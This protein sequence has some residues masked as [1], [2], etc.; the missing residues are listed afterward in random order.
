M[1]HI[2][3]ILLFLTFLSASCN[4]QKVEN[5]TSATEIEIPCMKLG[6]S[7]DTHFR[8]YGSAMSS[9]IKLAKEKAINSAKANLAKKIAESTTKSQLEIENLIETTYSI[10]CEKYEEENG[11]YT[12]HVAVEVERN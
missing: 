10:V 7:D 1:K 5:N 6:Q 8:A 9:N 3:F 11:R 12:T 2:L 4:V